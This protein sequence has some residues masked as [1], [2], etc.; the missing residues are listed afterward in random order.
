M[1][2][3]RPNRRQTLRVLGAMMLLL[4]VDYLLFPLVSGP[5]PAPPAR[6]E[7]GLWL[8]YWCYF[9]RYSDDETRELA[10]RLERDRIR[11]A[12]FHV[13]HVQADGKL[14]YRY[15]GHA[16]R[17]LRLLREE[18][19][20]VR[21]LA[22]VYAGNTGAGGLPRVRPSDPAVR[23]A[24]VEQARWLV[25]ECGF[26]GVQ[27]DY[28]ICPDADPGLLALLRETRAA[29]P[30][31][32]L[33][34]ATPLWAARPFHGWTWSEATFEQ[35]AES[36][37]QVAVMG[38][39]SGIY[40]PRAYAWLM[41]EQVAHVTTAILRANRRTGRECRMLLGVPTYARGGASHH[42]Y[43]ENLRVALRGVREGLADPRAEPSVFAGVAP[44]ADYTTQSREWEDYRQLWLPLIGSASKTNPGSLTTPAARRAP[45]H[46]HP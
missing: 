33:S 35:A 40:L 13:R 23:A 16:Q 24:M 3:P 22:W 26:D 36:C 29:L 15:L 31:A 7:N 32:V 34:V 42:A 5:G 14:R 9:G 19:P 27:W 44:F 20:S 45:G 38:Y 6:S 25:E 43:A 39:D 17:L 41:R 12:Y 10:R 28:E 18:A 2:L 37:D 4:L 1:R 30:N 46:S 21:A 8:R 11:S